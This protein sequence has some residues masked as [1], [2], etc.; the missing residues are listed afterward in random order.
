MIRLPQ[1]LHRQTSLPARSISNFHSNIPSGI[2]SVIHSKNAKSHTSDLVPG[3]TSIP[4]CKPDASA[5][6]SGLE[7]SLET[8][9]AASSSD[10][11]DSSSTDATDKT[12]SLPC[13]PLEAFDKEQVDTSSKSTLPMNGSDID[14]N[15]KS[16]ALK[17]SPFKATSYSTHSPQ[18]VQGV[19]PYSCNTQNKQN[20]LLWQMWFCT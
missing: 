1:Q 7:R 15:V 8:T 20:E 16:A 14:A 2:P 10:T 3:K 9:S 11:K 5:S 6:H 13:T 19:L 4:S 18:E 17:S 12:A